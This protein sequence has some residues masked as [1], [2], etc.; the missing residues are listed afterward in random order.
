MKISKYVAYII[1]FLIN[2]LFIVKYSNRVSVSKVFLI[3]T[4][5]FFLLILF[6]VFSKKIIKI[7][8]KTLFIVVTFLFF[9]LTIYI[10]YYVDGKTL[11]VDRWSAMQVAI[12]A[13][14]Q[15]RYPYAAIDHLGGRTSNLPSLIFI[16]TPFYL[17]G[18][19][20]LI[21]SFGFI[22]FVYIIIKVFKSSNDRLLCL[23]L[24]VS[25]PAYLWEIYAK[26]DLMT[27]F[28]LVL[29]FLIIFE[30]KKISQGN[31]KTGVFSFFSAALLLTRLTVIIPMSLLVVK[32]F[33]ILSFKR[34]ILFTS[35]FIL[36]VLVFLTICFF[37][38]ES[39][40]NFKLYNP[41]SLQN[42]QLPFLLSTLTILVPVVYSFKVIHF[43]DLIKYAVYTL[44][45]PICLSLILNILKNGINE[46]NFDISYFNI[47]LPFLLVDIVLTKTN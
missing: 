40:A 22:L 38:V 46:H 10:N 11:N 45:L 14:L 13:L 25:S 29:L 34:K 2:V 8:S 35:I 41:F 43:N 3:T 15:G 6:Y 32:R 23:L 17:I 16:G 36:T 30:K 4:Y 28:V 27:N 37:N 47:I 39:I 19:I 20:G 5:L 33:Y 12:E 21:Q 31:V 42:R 7:Y 26:S 44:L 1:Y 18:N 9:L 24:L